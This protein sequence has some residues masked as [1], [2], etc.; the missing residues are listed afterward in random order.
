[1]TGAATARSAD[2]AALADTALDEIAAMPGHLLR[3]CQQ[4]AV[5]LFLAEC[6]DTGLTPVQFAVLAA[7]DGAGAADAD[8]PDSQPI[9]QNRLGGLV[10]LDR[11]TVSLTVG[12][13][14]ERG[15]IDKRPSPADRRARLVALKPAGR[16]AL[17]AALPAVR[18]VQDQLLAPLDAGERELFVALLGRIAD[19][20]NEASR[21]PLRSD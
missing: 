21:A 7:L 17:D 19:A 12:K 16:A 10:A 3:R 1:M 5:A 9:D 14:A 11:T 13:L 18:R 4:I 2:D 15:L 6:R 20:G 8:A